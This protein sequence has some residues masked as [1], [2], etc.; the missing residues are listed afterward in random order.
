VR[1]ARKENPNCCLGSG[2]GRQLEVLALSGVSACVKEWGAVYILKKFYLV[3][4]VVATSVIPAL[5]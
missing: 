2:P 1:L 4:G 5:G 3:P